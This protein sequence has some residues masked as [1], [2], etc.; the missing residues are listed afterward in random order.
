M[1]LNGIKNIYKMTPI[2]SYII[3]RDRYFLFEGR[4]RFF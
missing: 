1:K 2:E 4:R 3:E